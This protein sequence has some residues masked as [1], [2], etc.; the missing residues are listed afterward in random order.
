MTRTHITWT[1]DQQSKALTLLDRGTIHPIHEDVY[2]V[3]STDG[4]TCYMTTPDVCTCPAYVLGEGM[5]CY[6]RLAVILFRN[7]PTKA[8]HAERVTEVYVREADGV[9][10]SV[11]LKP[12]LAGG[13]REQ[14]YFSDGRTRTLATTRRMTTS[15]ANAL[16][17]RLDARGYRRVYGQEAEAAGA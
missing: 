6:H 11:I 10:F 5:R 12:V 15:G 16:R 4:E 2:S 1:T 13:W 3:M 8:D 17:G 9:T 7:L 14:H